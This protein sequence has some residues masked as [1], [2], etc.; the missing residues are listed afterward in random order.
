MNLLLISNINA[1]C[2]IYELFYYSCKI[3]GFRLCL[4]SEGKTYQSWGA[5]ESKNSNLQLCLEGG[6]RA[7]L[8]KC[9]HL[10]SVLMVFLSLEAT[11]GAADLD[12]VWV[13][14]DCI[15]EQSVSNVLATVICMS[16]SCELQTKACREC[17]EVL[18]AETIKK[19]STAWVSRVTEKWW[20]Q[21]PKQFYHVWI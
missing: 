11:K 12:C 2:L 1:A 18:E 20:Q 8:L 9:C 10:S 3:P 21:L 5:A 16:P 14:L 15:L 19:R 7:Y 17:W 4:P 13:Q 6:V